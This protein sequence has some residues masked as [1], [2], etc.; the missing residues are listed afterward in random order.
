MMPIALPQLPPG[1]TPDLVRRQLQKILESSCFASA[2]SL[3]KLLEHLVTKYLAGEGA[4]LKESAIRVALYPERSVS[5]SINIRSQVTRL[6]KQLFMYCHGAGLADEIEITIPTGGYIPLIGVKRTQSAIAPP[7]RLAVLPF[8]SFLPS[9]MDSSFGTVVAQLLMSFLHSTPS[10]EVV[11]QLSFFRFEGAGP[12]VSAVGKQLDAAWIVH[13]VVSVLDG[14]RTAAV[15]LSGSDGRLRWSRRFECEGED[16]GRMAEIARC[17]TAELRLPEPPKRLPR[18]LPAALATIHCRGLRLWA[19]RTPD[20][21][22]RAVECFEDVIR[23]APDYAPAYAALANC[24]TFSMILGRRPAE[25][26]ACALAAAR[27]ALEVD[28]NEPEAR[29]AMGAVLGIF[30]HRWDEAEEHLRKA[31]ELDPRC[32]N[33]S[34]WYSSQLAAHGRVAEAL[35]QARALVSNDPLAIFLNV[36]IAKLLCFVRQYDEALSMLTELVSTAPGF[37]LIHH[38]LGTAYTA[39]GQHG[40]AIQSLET[41]AALCGR[42]DSWVLGALGNA[43]AV[44][45]NPDAA[46]QIL[47]ELESRSMG[48]YVPRTPIAA[49]WAGLGETEEA[50]RELDRARADNDFFLLML[51]VWSVFE[52][53]RTDPRFGQLT[54]AVGLPLIANS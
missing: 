2:E 44:S 32:A 41:A 5:E 22:R 7:T 37:Y 6:R 30:E 19:T 25:A 45:N 48:Q 36:H 10:L 52:P 27:K 28:A 50:F 3:R 13:G 20:A 34:G 29:A 33:A 8:A 24:H 40:R 26:R 47:S 9:G 53:L 18:T 16:M 54:A 23:L 31:L 12:D 42:Q 38:Q 51:P 39:L 49:I 11:G 43:Y 35:E 46:R 1:L 17:L 15:N 21:V 14:K 4:D